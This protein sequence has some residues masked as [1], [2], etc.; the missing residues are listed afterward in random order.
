MPS[1]YYYHKKSVP[2]F[3]NIMEMPDC[4]IDAFMRTHLPE[5]VIFHRNPSRYI[6]RRRETEQWLRTTFLSLGGNPRTDHPI[7]ATVGR[8]SYIEDQGVYQEWLEFPLS[9]FSENN[10]SFT[11]PD[12][13]VSRWLA[14]EQSRYFNPAHHGRV[15]TLRDLPGLLS[16]EKMHNDAWKSDDRKYDFFLEAQIWDLTPLSNLQ[17]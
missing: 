10:I 15:F 12:S 14:E 11:Y 2:R 9:L 5:D 6:K 8:S 13:Y 1:L 4:E 16:D 3:R 7:Y 17:F